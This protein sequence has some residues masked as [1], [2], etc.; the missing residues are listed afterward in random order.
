MQRGR[1]L[2]SR[3]CSIGIGLLSAFALGQAAAAQET[4]QT[5][6]R[7]LFIDG[8]DQLIPPDVIQVRNG[9]GQIINPVPLSD[10]TFA[11]QN[12]GRK[13]SFHFPTRSAKDTSYDVLLE[14]APIVYV[15]LVCNPMTGEVKSCSQKAWHQP[16]DIK[17]KLRWRP[18][19]NSIGASAVPP[20]NDAC[21]AA[22]TAVDGLNAFTT[23]D[24]TTDG[25]PGTGTACNAVHKDV[26]FKYTATG[27]GTTLI[28]TCPS[29]GGPSVTGFGSGVD[30][31]IA[32]Y[33]GLT[34]PNPVATTGCDDDSCSDVCCGL[35]SIVSLPTVAGTS[36]LIRIGGWS[37]T[38]PT[39]SGTFAIVAPTP[40]P[41]NDECAGALDTPCGSVTMVN[42]AS[43]T[44][45][46]TD[47]LFACR[48]GGATQGAGSLW[49]S[50]VATGTNVTVDTAASSSGTRDSMLHI[51]SG[52]CG[53]LTVIACNDDIDTAG[54]NFRSSASAGGLSIGTTY[55]I[56]LAA[57]NAAAQGPFTL[58]VTCSGVPEGDDCADPIETFCN[59]STT[60]DTT[61]FSEDPG[62]MPFSCR[63]PSA[64]TGFN[65]GWLTFIASD[66]SAF[67]STVGSTV[68]DTL[69]AVYDGSCGALVELCCNDDPAS[70]GTQA[71][72][73]CEG[74]S[75]G[76][77]YYL[78]IAS[79]SDVGGDIEVNML[80]PCPEPPAND[81][82]ENAEN[83]DPLPASVVVDNTFA[84]DD[85]PPPC[86]DNP[87]IFQNVWYSVT[88]TGNTLTATTCNGGTVVTDTR[89]TVYCGDCLAPMCVGGNDDQGFPPGPRDCASGI[90]L[91]TISWCSQPGANYLVTVGL[92][93]P[94]V[95][96][97]VIQLDVFDTGVDCDPTVQCLPVGACCLTDG[98][99]LEVPMVDCVTAGGTY[100]GDGTECAGQQNAVADGSF[101][102]GSPS[103]SWTE[104]S[105]NFGTPLCSTT[106]CSNGGGTGP[107]TGSWWAFFGGIPA[108]EEGLLEQMVTIPTDALTLDY[109]YE[110][111][112]SGQAGDFLEVLI[113]GSQ[114]ALY[115]AA[116]GPFVGYVLEQIPLGGF[117]DGGTHTLSFHSISLGS[118]FSNFFVDDVEIIGSV[119]GGVECIVYGACC[120]PDGTCAEITEDDCNAAGGCYNGDNT[121]CVDFDCLECFTLDFETDGAG[122]PLAHGQSLVTAGPETAYSH[123]TVSSGPENCVSDP[124]DPDNGNNG[125]AIF[126]STNGPAGQDPDLLVC[127]GNILYA[128]DNGDHSTNKFNSGTDTWTNPNDDADGA[129]FLFTFDYG[130]DAVS[131]DLIDIDSSLPPPTQTAFVTLLD[132]N[133]FTRT[134][135]VP[136][137]WTS[138]ATFCAGGN[139]GTLLLDNGGATQF[140]P[141]GGSATSSTQAGFDPDHVIAISVCLG[142]SG[143]IDNL[144]WCEP[145]CQ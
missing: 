77:T 123:P 8:Y 28:S 108:F 1:R 12:A 91:S 79:Y 139:A 122:G 133:N 127:Q 130:V 112:V 110:I 19:L 100:F 71:E 117:A 16:K 142:A 135:T 67:I 37:S 39:G 94:I 55:Y 113:D 6:A 132:V 9:A 50:F 45:A 40:P 82:C 107:R 93:D 48:V 62:D 56:E 131:I 70:G 14:Q 15:T 89:I 64:G 141:G 144:S 2:C 114:V 105:T 10:K 86:G 43:A 38:T 5:E 111:P 13:I 138:G 90:F 65:T 81:E 4:A 60:V 119:P 53:S 57:W 104:F 32:A 103:A 33:T 68:G 44:T 99:C 27:T 126:D 124:T 84:T 134:W 121:F 76:N 101:E 120:L 47:P 51:F 36:Y 54:G 20:A 41:A 66:T 52:T 87:V 106:T 31:K 85:N 96:P 80:C 143:G 49:Y 69:L 129:T 18:G 58:T 3:L 75:I 23:V 72:L 35:S 21:A 34:C 63:I 17:N 125:A 26:W 59:T 116:D 98:T 42:N 11:F 25:V 73:C 128:Q 61:A 29:V 24:A 137:G 83:L 102:G 74:L 145:T 95:A 140:G 88:G 109:W 136:G 115:T 22:A 92:W 78:Q 30:T 97:G 7:V 46:I 118:P